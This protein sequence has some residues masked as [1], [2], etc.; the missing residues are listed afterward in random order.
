MTSLRHKLLTPAVVL[1]VY[2]T[3][4]S[5]TTTRESVGP[6]RA[7]NTE[8]LRWTRAKERR[9]QQAGSY[10]PHRVCLQVVGAGSRDTPPSLFVF[11]DFNG[12]LFNCGE[13]TQ[14]LMQEHRLKIVRLDN[15]FVTRMNWSNVGGLSGMLLTM[16][17]TRVSGCVLSG[18]PQL[19]NYLDAIKTFSGSLDSIK[20][21]VRAPS[22][23]AYVDDTMAVHQVPIFAQLKDGSTDV[24]PRPDRSCPPP[25]MDQTVHPGGGAGPSRDDSLVVAFICRVQ[26]RKGN[27]LIPQ[28]KALGLPLGT[29]AMHPLV[30]ALK[31]GRSV[32]YEGREI[33]PEQVCTPTIQGP[34]FLVAECPSEEFVQ[35]LFTNQQLSRHQTGGTDEPPALVVHMTP[36]RILKMDRYQQWMERFPSTTEHLVLNEHVC[37]THHVRSFGLQT[38]LHMIH[39]Q[40]FPLP[41]VYR[42]KEPQA[43]LSVPSVRGQSL[44]KFQL[45]PVKEWQREAVFCSPAQF[46]EEAS[47]LPDFLEEVDKLRRGWTEAVEPLGTFSRDAAEPSA[48]SCSKDA[49]DPAGGSAGGSAGR[50]REYP[51]VVFLGTGSA[52]PMKTRNVS[53]TLV[54]ISS[55]QAVLLDCGEGTFGQ[56]VRHYGDEVD[57]VLSGVSA[58]FVSHMH[59]DHHS[60]LLTLLQQREQ[61]LRAVGQKISPVFLV[62]PDAM[63][64]WLQKYH[65]SC[66]EVLHSVHFISSKVLQVDAKVSPWQQKTI[67]A[68]LEKNNLEKFQTCHVHHCPDASACSF[69]HRSGWKLAFSGDTMPCNALV[70]IGKNANLLI[71]EA[72]LEDGLEGEAAE[73]RHSTTSQAIGVGVRMNASFIILNHFSQR[74][75]KIPLFSPDFSDRV[76]VAFDHMRISLGDLRTLPRLAPALKALFAEDIMEMEERRKLRENRRGQGA[77]DDARGVKRDLG[78]GQGQTKRLK[79]E[80]A[81]Q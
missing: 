70:H 66:E 15:I 43:A 65:A 19:E 45:R 25:G 22:D 59:A 29:A 57:E 54:H 35:P 13:G 20:L 56:L 48:E 5:N 60:G 4:A 28:A 77:P 31:E 32:T 9:S 81:P 11:S 61:A 40:I 37:T 2:R 71:H 18:P 14:R 73:K 3:M 26:P 76:G 7:R 24:P 55:H 51:E 67:K 36:E 8:P 52:L 39:P 17:D 62:G 58:V 64:T 63:M 33:R 41:R 47:A 21:S 50:G 27:F 30:T 6:N 69:I 10:G 68:L 12:Y 80:A 44:L 49:T 79:A 42:P 1:P 46:V 74:Y 16:K 78:G 72:T 75:A 34:L 38:Q 23:A 53:G